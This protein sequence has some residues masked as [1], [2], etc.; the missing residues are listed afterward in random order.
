MY[1]P[2]FGF[3]SDFSIFF[4][5]VNIGDYDSDSQSESKFPTEM[6]EIR[7]MMYMMDVYDGL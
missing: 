4:F 5:M 1:L 2:G 6:S 3:V 7:H